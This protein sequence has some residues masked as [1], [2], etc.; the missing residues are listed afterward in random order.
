MVIDSSVWTGG[1]L[2]QDVHHAASRGWLAQFLATGGRP[3]IPTLALA[4]VAG[5]ISRRT[6]NV[7]LGQNALAAVLATPGLYIVPL[8]RALGEEA[9]RLAYTYRL[10][11]AD[12]IFVATARQLGTPL[13][14][15]D[16][17]ILNRASPVIPVIHP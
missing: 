16:Q 6:G 12:A 14:T 4:E 17:E 7:S 3:I 15:W 10:R 2:D 9:A 8:S 11:G 1:L 13:I 5:A